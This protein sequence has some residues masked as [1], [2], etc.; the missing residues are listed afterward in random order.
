M[1]PPTRVIVATLTVSLATG[2]VPNLHIQR[3]APAT[4]GI[5]LVGDEPAQGVRV[6]RVLGGGSG[7]ETCALS[8]EDFTTGNDGTFRFSEA[9]RIELY[10]PLY[11]D[12]STPV[13]VCI[14]PGDGPIPA[15]NS[16]YLGRE[17][18]VSLALVCRVSTS[19]T[20]PRRRGGPSQ[21]TRVAACEPVR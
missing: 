1:L 12:P 8:G 21:S 11:G 16:P 4:G 7:P 5:V 9:H 18:P 15:W 2:C 20:P 19:T 10:A 6:R 13:A 14:D 17:P 3:T